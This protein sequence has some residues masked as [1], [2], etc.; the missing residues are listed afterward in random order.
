ML[1]H[2]SGVM[3]GLVPAIRVLLAGRAKKDM[4]AREDGVPAARR[5][6]GVSAG[7]TPE[8]SP[9]LCYERRWAGFSLLHNRCSPP[10]APD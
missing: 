3:A 8:I 9:T 1:N 4:D 10:L 6:G 5:G 7:M 2:L